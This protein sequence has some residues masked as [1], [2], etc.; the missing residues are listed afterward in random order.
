MKAGQKQ[1]SAVDLEWDK[2]PDGKAPAYSVEFK[3]SNKELTEDSKIV[4]SIADDSSSSQVQFKV[5]VSD[6][7]GRSA[8]LP[9]VLP[10]MIE[11]EIFK[12]PL[13]YL[14]PTKELVFQSFE[15]SIKDIKNI[16][17]DFNVNEIS[18]IIFIFDN[19]EKGHILIDNIG[20]R[21]EINNG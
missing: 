11:G 15:I 18:S 21:E 8:E 16:N 13:S 2:E 1:N 6:K 12:K 19:K 10:S 20:V 4:F 3:D 5:K 9:F 7:T 17:L 14:V